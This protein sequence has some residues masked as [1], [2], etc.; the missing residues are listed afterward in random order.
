MAIWQDGKGFT[1]P[2]GFFCF[3][4]TGLT[5]YVGQIHKILWGC[6]FTVLMKRGWILLDFW[7]QEINSFSHIPEKE[8]PYSVDWR[9]YDSLDYW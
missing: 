9:H 1:V 6:I 8:L 4:Y 5:D 3:V 7:W 2:A